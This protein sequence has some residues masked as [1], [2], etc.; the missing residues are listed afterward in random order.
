MAVQDVR[1]NTMIR[2]YS[3]TLDFMGTIENHT[4]LLWKRR[5]FEPGGFEVHAPATDKN[6]RLLKPGNLIMRRGSVEAGIIGD[7]ENEESDIKNEVTRQGRFLSFYFDWRLIQGRVNFSGTVED[8]MRQ[9]VSVNSEAVPLVELGERKGFAET[10][11]FQATYKNLSSYLTK[12]AKSSGLG[13][14]LRP[15]FRQKKL[16]FEVY[17]GVDRTLSQGINSRVIF[18]ES[19]RNINNALYKYNDQ[20]Y[21]TR[22]VVG[23]EG[24]G[25]NRVFV[26]V[27]GGKGLG[28]RE[29]F[30]DARDLS[31]EGLTT[32]QY[33]EKLRQ[34]GLE[35]LAEHI[36]NES[37]ECEAEA[38]INFRYLEHYDLGDIV[39]VDKRKWDI[40]MNQ[41][42]TELQEVYQYGGMFVVPTLGDAIPETIDWRDD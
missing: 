9:L 15:D 1:K 19:Y 37:M 6:L 32:E 30:V 5:Y 42:L 11:S 25:M 12:L 26:T 31:S 33:K 34:R 20:L 10:V 40:K 27:G 18:S 3:P 39:S 7:L 2:V 28:L 41:R 13:Y 38:D 23:G 21:R 14:R 8:A 36:I 22:A 24:E 16:I 4:S 17:K 35:K 29:I